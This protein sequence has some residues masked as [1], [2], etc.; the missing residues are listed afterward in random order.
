MTTGPF[1]DANRRKKEKK[2]RRAREKEEGPEMEAIRQAEQERLR[3]LA[4]VR[5]VVREEL[6]A[7]L[8][9]THGRGAG[10]GLT[11]SSRCGDRHIFTSLSC[12]CGLFHNRYCACSL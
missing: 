5:R 6:R 9:P 8:G 1:A 12:C 10:T 2:E 7:A 11:F 3:Q 4:S